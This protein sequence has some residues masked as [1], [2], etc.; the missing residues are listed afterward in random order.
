MKVGLANWAL[1]LLAVGLTL[2]ATACSPTDGSQAATNSVSDP[3]TPTASQ[4][5][6]GQPRVDDRAETLSY[7]DHY[8]AASGDEVHSPAYTGDGSIPAGASAQCRDGTF[9]F[10]EHRRGT[11]S[12]HGGVARWLKA[13][14]QPFCVFR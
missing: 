9:S 13:R 6:Y 7:D 3:Y 14:C 11:C 5:A 10:S 12:H 4:T 8:R 2:V 1:A